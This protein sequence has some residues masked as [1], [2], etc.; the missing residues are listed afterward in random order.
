MVATLAA[1][2]PAAPS[3]PSRRVAG[4]YVLLDELGV[5]GMGMGP[6]ARDESDGRVVALKQLYYAK[7]GTRRR[8]VEALFEREYHTLVRLRHPRIIEVYDYG[9]METGPYYTM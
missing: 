5:G 3:V 1:P 6:R 4:R 2:D 7:A 9:V 8:T